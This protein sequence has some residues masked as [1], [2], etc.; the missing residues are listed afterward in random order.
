MHIHVS[1]FGNHIDYVFILACNIQWAASS[2]PSWKW[3]IHVDDT[4]SQSM[5]FALVALGVQKDAVCFITHVGS[6]ERHRTLGSLWRYAPVRSDCI[7]PTTERV[8]A[9][10]D[11]DVKLEGSVADMLDRFLTPE[12]QHVNALLCRPEYSFTA[13]PSLMLAGVAVFRPEMLRLASLG[14]VWGT[15]SELADTYMQHN[16]NTMEGIARGRGYG[17]DEFVLAEFVLPAWISAGMQVMWTT[18]EPDEESRVSRYQLKAL[19][20]N[21]LVPS[22]EFHELSN[23]WNV[24]AYTKLNKQRMQLR[25]LDQTV[26]DPLLP[27]VKG[28]IQY[29]EKWF[30]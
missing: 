27:N 26:Y 18:H 4:V 13:F 11:A 6:G 22:L 9:V 14:V 19:G 30:P 5:R 3:V 1:L 8:V 24:S 29:N 17:F 20:L 2:R 21:N 23:S 15:L 12:F 10:L 28:L 25:R 7:H 16:T